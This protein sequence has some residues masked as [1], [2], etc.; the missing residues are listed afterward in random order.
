MR[1]HLE[2]YKPPATRGDCVAGTPLTSDRD[3]RQA[4]GAQCRAY[5]CRH[6]LLRMDSA[7]V[8]GRRHDGLAPEWTLVASTLATAPSCALDVADQHP[9]GLSSRE[10]ARLAGVSTRRV[11][12]I[13]R[14]AL[15]GEGAVRVRRVGV[16]E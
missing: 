15:G 1:L 5:T 3:T 7:D 2:Q 9:E 6:N 4:G 12:Q 16:E 11:E 14:A 8:P 10:V 13:V